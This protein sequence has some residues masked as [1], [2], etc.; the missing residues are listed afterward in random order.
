MV[1]C[2]KCKGK[3][4]YLLQSTDPE[5]VMSGDNEEEIKGIYVPCNLCAGASV[6][7]EM[8]VVL[9]KIQGNWVYDD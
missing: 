1:K 8:E 2:P 3:G 5:Y 4:S 6:L 7:T 9:A